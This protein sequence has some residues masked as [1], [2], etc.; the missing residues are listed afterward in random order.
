MPHQFGFQ[1]GT[2]FKRVEGLLH[3]YQ[4]CVDF[5]RTNLYVFMHCVQICMPH[6]FRVV[7]RAAKKARQKLKLSL[8]DVTHSEP[9]EMKSVNDG[10][11]WIRF[12]DV[13]E[14][15]DK[16][17]KRLLAAD[18][19]INSWTFCFHDA[20]RGVDYIAGLSRFDA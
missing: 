14:F 6:P 13:I 20:L 3:A 11:V 15:F 9:F 12:D 8:A 10:S 17:F 4:P 19:L 5:S 1:V 7:L 16:P 18:H 2:K